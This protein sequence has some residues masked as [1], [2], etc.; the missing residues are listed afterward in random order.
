MIGTLVVASSIAFAAIFAV[1]WWLRPALR[2][3]IEAPKHGFADRVRRYD[4]A[5][6]KSDARGASTDAA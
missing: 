5:C 2:R 6:R 3:A 1:A 4:E